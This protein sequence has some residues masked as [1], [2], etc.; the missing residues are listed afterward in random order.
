MVKISIIMPVYNDE[1]RLEKSIDSFLSQTLLDMELICINDGSSDGSL[2]ILNDFAKMHSNIRVFSQSNQGAGKARNYGMSKAQGEYIGFLDSDDVF[3]DSRALEKLYETAIEN[4]ADMASGNIKLIDSNDELSSFTALEYCTEP[5]TINPEDYGIPWSF[6]K[7]IYKTDF[8]KSNNIEFPDLLRGQDPVFLAEAL[9]KVDKVHM[10]P[11]D[12]YAYYYINGANQCDTARKRH[13]HMMHYRMVFDYLSDSKFDRTRLLFRHEM[14]SFIDMMGVEGGRDILDASRQI[15]NDTP[16]L[17]S[18]FEDSFY[19][20]HREDDLKDLANFKANPEMPRISVLIPVYNVSRFLHESIESLLNQT[21]ED[22]ELVC[23]NDGSTDNSLEILN[24]FSKNDPRVKVFNQENEGS[25]SARNRALEE[26]CGKYVYFF[27][28]DD[29][30][31]PN[32][33][34]E[35][36]KNAINNGSDF[37]MIKIATFTDGQPVDYGNPVFNFDKVF[38][39]VNFNKF[40]FNYHDVKRH[41][42]N[43]AFA[44]WTKLYKKSFLDRYDDFRFDVGLAFDDVPFHVKSMLRA[45]FISFVPKFLYHYRDSNPDSVNNTASNNIDIFRIIEIVEEF[46][47]KS[48]HFEEFRQEFNQFKISQIAN[49]AATSDS[50]EYLKMAKQSISQIDDN[51]VGDVQP[52]YRKLY[53]LV[54]ESDDLIE[55]GNDYRIFMLEEQSESL[56][57]QIDSLERKKINLTNKKSEL[58]NKNKQLKKTNKQLKKEWNKSKEFNKDLVSSNSWKITR[59]LRNVGKYLK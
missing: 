12:V 8:L 46:L 24:E 56:K 25:G 10:V 34:E 39:G 48:N 53:S 31:P 17:L 43:S 15:F 29:Y 4:D 21:F 6:Y 54:L 22:F 7:S 20:K 42:L 59:H 37:V 9:S 49:Y 33:L 40:V 51:D 30:V 55:Y 13:D 58:K 1:N 2:D 11:V 32:C 5:K 16:E 41:V 26:A 35:L 19:Y 50:D 52:Y 28:P 27:D 14:F 38:K 45:D 18:E 44:P 47:R 57:L 3:I 36:Y 23:V